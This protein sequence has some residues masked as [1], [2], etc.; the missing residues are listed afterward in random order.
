MCDLG[1]GP[2][3]EPQFLPFHNA[4]YVDTC[5]VLSPPDREVFAVNDIQAEE[6][7]L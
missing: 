4:E 7:G 6:T 3:L 5:V 2:R 1:L